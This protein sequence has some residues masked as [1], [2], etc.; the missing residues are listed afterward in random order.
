MEITGRTAVLFIL[1]D[2][3]E[4]V[5]GTALF[6]ERFE[7]EG[8]DAAFSPLHVL[9]EDLPTVVTAL[10]RSQNVAGFGV[11]IPHKIDVVPLLD[12]LTASAQRAGSVNFVRRTAEGRLIGT[13]IDGE[14]FLVGLANRGIDV[15][16]K[17]ILQFG[18]GGVG[19]AVAFATALAGAAS[20]TLVN[21]TFSTAESLAS[22]VRDVAPYLRVEARF[23]ADPREFDLVINATPNGMR[24]QPVAVPCDLSALPDGGAVAEIVITPEETLLVRAAHAKGLQTSIG[25]DMLIGQYQLM[26]DF[27]GLKER[28]RSA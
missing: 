22:A 8:I 10:R 27:L 4:H 11:T 21:R 26:R 28:V 25:R 13:N 20:I 14:G 9:P 23:T 18:A 5:R 16:G 19:R 1:C 24:G 2:P 3:V 6:N 15:A 12:E 7:N 17:R